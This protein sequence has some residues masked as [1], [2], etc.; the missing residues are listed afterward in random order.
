M[1]SPEKLM[2]DSE[3]LTLFARTRSQDAFRAL[4]ENHLKLVFSAALRQVRDPALAEDVTQGVF[5]VLARKAPQLAAR[6]STLRAWLLVVTRYA[7]RD[8]LQRRAVRIHHEQKAA[9]MNAPSSPKIDAEWLGS[10]L[11]DALNCLSWPDRTAIA[12]FYLENLSLREVGR[13]LAISEEAAAKR[14]RRALVRLRQVLGCRS[15]TCSADALEASLKE[16]NAT[17]V[18]PMLLTTVLANVLGHS[19]VT[20]GGAAIAQH[21]LIKLALK[22]VA[23]FALGALVFAAVAAP[24]VP[25]VYRAIFRGPSIITTVSVNTP[26]DQ[27]IPTLVTHSSTDNGSVGL[28]VSIDAQNMPA[29]QAFR[30]V[31]SQAKVPYMEIPSNLSSIVAVDTKTGAQG[32][33][34]RDMPPNLFSVYAISPVTLSMHHAPF[35]QVMWELY[36]QTGVELD[37]KDYGN[38]GNFQLIYADPDS[39]TRH[40]HFISV[41]G[42]F[43]VELQDVAYLQAK[44]LIR[45]DM[46]AYAF[47]GW[48]ILQTA[49]GSNIELQTAVDN[50]GQSLLTDPSGRTLRGY[51]QSNG[52]QMSTFAFLNRIPNIGTSLA[53]LEGSVWIP[54]GE[55]RK[56]L[57]FGNLNQ[58]NQTLKV[59]GD[60]GVSIIFQDIIPI[61]GNT[62]RVDYSISAPSD[63]KEELSSQDPQAVDLQLTLSQLQWN[64]QSITLLDSHGQSLSIRPGG[65]GGGW[66]SNQWQTH[67]DFSQNNGVGPPAKLV[68][69]LYTGVSNVQ[70]PFEFKN[71]P[72]PAQ[73]AQ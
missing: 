21:L 50:L 51:F 65:G 45:V 25:L 39:A 49:Y 18:P 32:V 71:V 10:I 53:N 42:A 30:I 16:F 63:V 22:K 3:L 66:R 41:A 68:L 70:V 15:M 54:I 34:Y 38:F 29:E 43:A 28:L 40:S 23:V 20:G 59:P 35:W 11:D 36:Q 60:S 7:A 55:N 64:A 2:T 61:S 31:L 46:N 33:P 14:V 37:V 73:S 44:P 19:A 6:P 67:F 58:P 17:T 48:P 47:P 57:A 52:S 5:L 8:A 56:E 62:Y 27:T 24:V 1:E 69:N 72:L 4:L 13:V 26:V 9:I 12:M